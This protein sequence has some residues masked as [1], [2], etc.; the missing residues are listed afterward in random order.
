MEGS[1]AGDE[2][3]GSGSDSEVASVAA[4]SCAG[5]AGDL[6]LGVSSTASDGGS[7][8]SDA[9]GAST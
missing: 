6:G 1:K 5:G 8:G 7:K 9:G 4:G 3:A 2:G